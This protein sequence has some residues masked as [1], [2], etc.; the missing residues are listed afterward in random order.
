MYLLSVL[1]CTYDC[2]CITGF[3]LLA[4]LCTHTSP[5]VFNPCTPLMYSF[6]VLLSYIQVCVMNLHSSEDTPSGM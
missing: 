1:T 3:F 2:L 6:A 4:V 5:I